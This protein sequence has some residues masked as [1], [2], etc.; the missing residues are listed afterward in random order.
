MF[1]R[2]QFSCRIPTCDPHIVQGVGPAR[3][4]DGHTGPLPSYLWDGGEV[5]TV[6]SQGSG[7]FELSFQFRWP[8]EVFFFSFF[9]HS[10]QNSFTELE[11]SL[12]VGSNEC[13]KNIYLLLS[14]SVICL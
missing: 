11:R 12:M 13:F 8:F 14:I 9:C 7:S 5:S 6:C 3:G 2:A 4:K 10:R 1:P